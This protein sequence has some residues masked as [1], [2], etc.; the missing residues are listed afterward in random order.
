MRLKLTIQDVKTEEG[1]LIKVVFGTLNNSIPDNKGVFDKKQDINF[2]V[3][4]ESIKGL[5]KIV[6][7]LVLDATILKERELKAK[8]IAKIIKAKSKERLNVKK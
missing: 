5:P 7:N 3:A 4:L 8:K 1:D 2:T 6:R